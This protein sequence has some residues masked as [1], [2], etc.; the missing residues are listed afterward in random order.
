MNDQ[1]AIVNLRRPAEFEVREELVIELLGGN[2]VIRKDNEDSFQGQVPV[3]ELTD[4][5]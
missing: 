1:P 4:A 3:P 2:V 5:S